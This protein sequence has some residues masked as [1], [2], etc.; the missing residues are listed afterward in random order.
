MDN[1]ASLGNSQKTTS[2]KPTKIKP[3]DTAPPVPKDD[4][5]DKDFAPPKNYC[6]CSKSP[7][8][9]ISLDKYGNKIVEDLPLVRHFAVVVELC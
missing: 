2:S 8:K 3:A 9:D 5:K 4:P 6:P 7:I 1:V